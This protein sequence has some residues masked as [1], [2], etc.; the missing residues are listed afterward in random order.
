MIY[1]ILEDKKVIILPEFQLYS[2]YNNTI[3][4]PNNITKIKQTTFEHNGKTYLI[5]TVFLG[6]S[7]QIYNNDRVKEPLNKNRFFETMIFEDEEDKYVYRHSS[8]YY[9]A[10]RNH[11]KIV[12]SLKDSFSNNGLNRFK[13]FLKQQNHEC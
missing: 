6:Y 10:I 3:E 2:K 7:L 11:N 5:S 12:K 4:I 1:A 13:A 9:S 8:K